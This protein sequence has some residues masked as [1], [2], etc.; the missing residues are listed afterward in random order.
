MAFEANIINFK[1]ECKGISGLVVEYI[2]A[3]DMA[4]ARFPGDAHRWS[5]WGSA[6]V[7]ARLSGFHFTGR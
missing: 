1:Q 7:E 2:V 5:Q 6:G 3:I 4:R